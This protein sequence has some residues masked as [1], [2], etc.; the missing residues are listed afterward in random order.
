MN[1]H[2]ETS[3]KGGTAIKALDPDCGNCNFESDKRCFEHLCKM[4]QKLK[5]YE[6]IC[7]SPE[8]LLTERL[9]QG[10]ISTNDKLPNDDNYYLYSSTSGNVDISFYSNGKWDCEDEGYQ[11]IAWRPRPEQYMEGLE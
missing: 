6:D 8:Q 1:R 2:T 5:A 10:W 9:K 4:L 3:V 11:V 7:E